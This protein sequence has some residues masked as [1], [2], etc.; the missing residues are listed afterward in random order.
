MIPKLCAIQP[1]RYFFEALNSYHKKLEFTIECEV[2]SII[3]FLDIEM[4]KQ[5]DGSLII[6][7]Y[8]FQTNFVRKNTELSIKPSNQSKS[9]NNK[10]I[11]FRVIE[12]SHT[13]F[14]KYNVEKVKNTPINNNYNK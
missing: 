10:K 3:P 7:W 2:D 5:Q 13:S 12:L 14:H 11:I 8:L 6:N 4:R 9:S 1:K